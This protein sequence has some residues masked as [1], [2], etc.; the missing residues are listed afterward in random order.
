M[1]LREENSIQT[2]IAQRSGYQE[3][4][5]TAA[6]LPGQDLG[7]L[8]LDV[9]QEIDARRASVVS[10][11]I[12]GVSRR[13]GDAAFERLVAA[14]GE[15]TWPVLWIS[16]GADAEPPAAAVQLWAV[17]DLEVSPVL[18]DGRSIGVCYEDASAAY[19]RLGG[20]LPADISLA[21]GMQAISVFEQMEAGLETADMNF[22]DVL[23]TWFYNDKITAWYPQFNQ[24]RDT[25]FKRWRVFE[26]FVP[27][28]T[29]VGGSNAFGAAL[30]GG[31]IAVKAKDGSVKRRPLP[32][33][34]QCPA[35]DYGSSFS[36]AVEFETDDHRRVYVSGTA[37]IAPE[38]HTV[39]I[40]D[41]EGQ[42][43][44]TMEVIYA[45]LES[46]GMD[47][48]DVCRSIAYFKEPKEFGLFPQYCEAQGISDLPVAY[49]KDDI[50]RDNLLFE[51]ELDAIVAK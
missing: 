36:R 2:R 5:I 19:C 3:L 24:A 12:F 25:M 41:I 44:R 50:C 51:V 6:P 21:E 7:S 30:T 35:L 33:P 9:F 43:A 13:A 40:D 26:G 18:H 45:I 27:A 31:L 32:S 16:E 17:T 29:A 28:S 14:R 34:L 1:N 11:E 22:H 8:L 42:I 46:R 38:G 23:R 15:I 48:K 20:I 10:H 47:W 39:F 37:S 49:V 4:F